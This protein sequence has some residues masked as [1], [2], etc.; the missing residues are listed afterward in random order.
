MGQQHLEIQKG[1]SIKITTKTSTVKGTV[2]VFHKYDE[3]WDIEIENANVSGGY[4]R[5]KQWQDGGY[6]SE[7]NGQTM[8]DPELLCGRKILSMIEKERP[9]ITTLSDED[10]KAY[11]VG[12]KLMSLHVSENFLDLKRG[13]DSSRHSVRGM[14]YS[15][16]LYDSNILSTMSNKRD[17]LVVWRNER[18]SLD[19]PIR[20][21]FWIKPTLEGEVPDFSIF[22]HYQGGKKSYKRTLIDKIGNDYFTDFTEGL[23]NVTLSSLVDDVEKYTQ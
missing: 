7:L 1:D 20:I 14:V 15:V 2:N 6:V 8:G 21:E 23:G 17:L 4:C 12:L 13:P 9:L 22:V 19:C 16:P 3:G 11:K 18:G 10:V 5:W